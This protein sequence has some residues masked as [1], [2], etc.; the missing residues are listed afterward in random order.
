MKSFLLLLLILAG[1]VSCRC[2]D[3]PCAGGSLPFEVRGFDSADL[4]GVELRRYDTAGFYS[5]LLEI[6]PGREI[7]YDTVNGIPHVLLDLNVLTNFDWELY[8]PAIQKT[9]RVY[10]L[11]YESRTHRVCS[12][13]D[14]NLPCGTPITSYYQDGFYHTAIPPQVDHSE[15]IQV[16]R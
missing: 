7:Y 4:K 6:V 12:S 14:E 11:Q 13:S 8:F 16:T 3:K 15:F 10:D 2:Y 5:R 1:I 9:V